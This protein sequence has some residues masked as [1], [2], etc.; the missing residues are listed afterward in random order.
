MSQTEAA[1]ARRDGR[2]ERAERTR[3]A[4]AQAM[5]GLIAGGDLKPTAEAIAESAGVS[6]R[7][8]FHHY[9]NLES[10][11]ATVADLQMARLDRL[12]QPVDAKGSLAERIERFT[13][14]RTR[15]LEAIT[16]VRRAALLTEPFSHE[17]GT[18]LAAT[19]QRGQRE[20]EVLFAPELAR[21]PA[22]D[23][24]EILAAITTIASWSAWEA[25]RSH[26]GLSAAQARR[27]MAR[28]VTGMLEGV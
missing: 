14:E 2:A 20:V 7:T 10:L 6:L 25:M 11:L 8:V 4:V 13:A 12:S 22:A 15:L 21:L 5:L 19:R 23:R 1:H 26:Q 18:R 28:T 9:E 3:E 24:R 16:P 27:V 17:I